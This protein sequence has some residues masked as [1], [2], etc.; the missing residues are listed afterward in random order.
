MT[1]ERAEEQRAPDIKA[2]PEFKAALSEATSK[3]QR[4]ASEARRETKRIEQEIGQLNEK[5]STLTEGIEVAKLAGDDETEGQKVRER[6]KLRKELDAR[7]KQLQVGETEL[8]EH[9]RILAIDVLSGKFG[10]PATELEKVDDLKDMEIAA[11]D[12]R[13][14]HRDDAGGNGQRGAETMRET[15]GVDSG[16]PL[17]GGV[18]MQDPITDPK[19]WAGYEAKVKA[20]MQ[21]ELRK[22]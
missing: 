14:E 11:R 20:Q 22:R 8:N 5:V 15:K 2:T 4:E 10:I 16:E 7:A 13:W 12:W 3:Y 21:R 18:A 1:T 17:R 9:R 19:G 6:L